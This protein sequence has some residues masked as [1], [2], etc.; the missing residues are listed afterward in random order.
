M[1]ADHYV[2]F[3]NGGPTTMANGVTACHD[4]NRDK[5]AMNGDDYKNRRRHLIGASW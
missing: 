1:E 5:G 3:L 4:C 2:S